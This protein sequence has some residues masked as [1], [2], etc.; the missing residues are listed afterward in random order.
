MSE[1]VERIVVAAVV[2]LLTG[3]A[4]ALVFRLLGL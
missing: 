2:G 4:S 3:A 1:R